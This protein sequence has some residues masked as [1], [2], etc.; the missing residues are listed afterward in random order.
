MFKAE[1]EKKRNSSVCKTVERNVNTKEESKR[2]CW[3]AAGVGLQGGGGGGTG[4]A[5]APPKF[6]LV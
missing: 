6:L 4:R 1:R 3:V 2:K 5:I